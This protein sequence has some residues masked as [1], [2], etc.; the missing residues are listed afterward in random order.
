MRMHYENASHDTGSWRVTMLRFASVFV[1][2]G[3][4][5]VSLPA[6]VTHGQGGG[7]D[8]TRFVGVGDSLTAGV[9]D[10]ALHLMGQ[11]QGFYALLA[12]SM[13][14]QVVLPLIAEPGIPSPDPAHGIGLMLQDPGTCDVGDITFA[15]GV[16]T[17]RVNPA[18]APTNV[19]VP[20][21]NIG[22]ALTSK[23]D[24]DPAN[25]AGTADTAEDFVLGF[26]YC[27]LAPPQNIPRSQIEEAVALQP[28][29][30]SFWLGSNDAL[31]AVLAGTIS[32]S[33][34]TPPAEFNANAE[35]A[36]DAIAHTEAKAVVLNVPDVT[37][38]PNLFSEADLE[39]LTGL[40][41][42]K[43]TRLLGIQTSDFVLLSALPAVQ[44]IVDGSAQGPL[45]P[46][47][48]LTKKEL[49]KIKK[50]IKSYNKTLRNL[51][52]SR[53]WAFVD[54]NALFNEYHQNGAEIP[55]V[56]TLTTS[57]LGGIFGLDGV[58]PSAT[59]NALIAA[60]T[61]DA[62]NSRYQTALQ[63]PDV[64]A[65]AAADPE[66]CM[67]GSVAAPTLRQFARLAPAATAAESTILRRRARNLVASARLAHT[68]ASRFRD[69]RATTDIRGQRPE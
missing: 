3:M 50:K 23:W 69:A 45:S 37:V 34:P 40:K 25:V 15:V 49:K 12:E 33:T 11:Q 64:A 17:G 56:G 20:G 13:N 9:K 36:A 31:H 52:D 55:G 41:T 62:I 61:V 5:L 60:A 54:V 67:I 32:G 47:Q 2:A 65:I 57:Y 66:V 4:M 53:G 35:A 22:Q 6:R 28:T 26:P 59:G 58:H 42:G 51:A 68:R 44:S 18:Q 38:I 14:S 43:L 27:L 21:Q 39:N 30:V 29:F 19:A 8:F 24:I 46:N 1:V 48:I 10:G 16:S 7:A 63:P